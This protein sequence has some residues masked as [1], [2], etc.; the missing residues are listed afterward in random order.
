VE[1]FAIENLPLAGLKKITRLHLGDHRGFLSRIFCRE[2]LQKAGWVKPVAQINLTY[3]Q[4][5]GT[6]RGMHFQNPPHAEMKLV[7]CLRGKIFDVAVDLRRDSPTLLQWRSAILSAENRNALLIPE[8]FAHGFQSL[9]PDVEI[10]YLHS[11]LY[12]PQAEAGLKAT[13]PRL[14]IEWP[15]P[16]KELY[17]RDANHPLIDKTFHGIMI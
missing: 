1:R 13:D 4:K 3:T 15:L 16:I 7:S 10:L 5:K 17:G 9:T 6:I 11:V 14:G 2:E 12:T 8:G